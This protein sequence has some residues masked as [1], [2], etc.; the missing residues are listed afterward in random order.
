MQVA[1]VLSDTRPIKSPQQDEL[2]PKST[3]AMKKIVIHSAL[4]AKHASGWSAVCAFIGWLKP[5]FPHRMVTT[6]LTDVVW[7]TSGHCFS[8]AL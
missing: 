7:T 1:L 8:F 6:C 3:Y 4:Y 5:G 2:R